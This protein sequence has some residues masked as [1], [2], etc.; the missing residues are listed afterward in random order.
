MRIKSFFFCMLLACSFAVLP[1]FAQDDD[2]TDPTPG[3]TPEF[4]LADDQGVAVEGGDD[5]GT[6][7]E[8]TD[9][10]AEL[11]RTKALY[12][13]IRGRLVAAYW[14]GRILVIVCRSYPSICA[15]IKVRLV[16]VA[17]TPGTTVP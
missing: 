15:I 1:A 17:T 2:T 7:R 5:D 13:I 9:I 12:I 4:N 6:V 14:R 10:Q 16:P 3:E 8:A 11:H